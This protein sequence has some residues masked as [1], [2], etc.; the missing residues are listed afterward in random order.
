[1]ELVNSTEY[2]IMLPLVTEQT[3]TVFRHVIS[4]LEWSRDVKVCTK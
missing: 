3:R 1:L 4:D 2:G